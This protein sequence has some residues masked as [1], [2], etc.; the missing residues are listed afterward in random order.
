MR[1]LIL[2][3]FVTMG[4]L[5]LTDCQKVKVKDFQACSPFPPNLGGGATCDWLLHKEQLNLDSAQWDAKLASWGPIEIIQA[6]SFGDLKGE[7]EK[8]CSLVKCEQDQEA[9]AQEKKILAGLKK[10]QQMA[11]SRVK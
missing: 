4:T 8:L 10:L 2:L 1:T 7:I 6:T 3:L 5:L 9:A 11:Q